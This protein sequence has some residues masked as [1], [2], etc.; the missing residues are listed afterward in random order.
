MNNKVK[1]ALLLLFFVIASYVWAQRSDTYVLGLRTDVIRTCL[2]CGLSVGWI[3]KLSITEKAFV[4]TYGL[5]ALVLRII[6]D[7]LMSW[8][9]SLNSLGLGLLIFYLFY[10]PLVFLG[11]SLIVLV[12]VLAPVAV[13]R[14]I[15]R[16]FFSS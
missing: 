9:S 7:S 5:P 14:R 13:I 16:I 3:D 12:I 8:T 11:P 10:Y 6:V 2:H 1:R 15:M 4:F